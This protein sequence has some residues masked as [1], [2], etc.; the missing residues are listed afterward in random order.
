M[1]MQEYILNEIKS[2]G[3]NRQVKRA[4]E[5]CKGLPVTHIPVVEN[6]RLIG[7]FLESDIQTY[8]NEETLLK[9]ISH[10]LD[11]FYVNDDISLLELIKQ[12][13]DHDCN[14]IPV[15]NKEKEYLGYF[16]LSD[17]LDLFSE[18]PFLLEHGTMLVVEKFHKD[19]SFSEISQIVESNNGKILGL[20][21]SSKNGDTTQI[22]LK[23][24]SE[25]I[26][27]IIQTFRRYNYNVLSEHE[28]DFYL[29][30]LKDRSEYLQ[31]YLNM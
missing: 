5:I 19:Y 31:R 6:N 27:E 17:I 22:T 16:E 20:Y 10:L 15:L 14:I 7:C 26:N 18:H 4:K 9:E 25:D 28:D 29:Q 2:I 13:A 8:E 21:I 23:I 3:L 30:D 1:N 11:F 12:F 24:I